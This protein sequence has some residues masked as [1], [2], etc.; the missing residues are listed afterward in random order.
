[1]STVEQIDGLL[2]QNRLG[3]HSRYQRRKAHDDALDEDRMMLVT[4]SAQRFP[5]RLALAQL[6]DQPFVLMSSQ[7]SPTYNR[8]VLELCARH[9][10]RPRVVQR[11]PRNNHGSGLGPRRPWRFH[12]S[13]SFPHNR[14]EGIRS[15]R[16]TDR[17]AEWTVAAAWRKDDSNPLIPQFL[18][19]LKP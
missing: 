17:A 3:L 14:F 15:H 2:G 19:L 1:M 8:H 5:A 12:D 10:F 16:I 9:G 7:R 4:S 11:S 18:R 13:P 6:K